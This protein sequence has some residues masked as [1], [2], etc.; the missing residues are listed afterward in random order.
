M[1]LYSLPDEMLQDIGDFLNMPSDYF[2]FKY[3]CSRARAAIRAK[4]LIPVETFPEIRE[5]Y[6]SFWDTNFSRR[7]LISGR[8]S[9]TLVSQ[10]LKIDSEYHIT[11]FFARRSFSCV[12]S[13]LSRDV[14]D[15]LLLESSRRGYLWMCSFLIHDTYVCSGLISQCVEIA[16]EHNQFEV[17]KLLADKHLLDLSTSRSDVLTRLITSGG[18]YDMF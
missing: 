11:D 9:D 14:F 13:N 17:L 1:L 5:K 2:N 6:C 10:I 7:F 12:K 15:N 3:T 8:I 4:M 16:V 18:S